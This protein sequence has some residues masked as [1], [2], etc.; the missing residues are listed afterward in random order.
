MYFSVTKKQVDIFKP[1][2]VGFVKNVRIH[3]ARLIVKFTFLSND[4]IVSL[5]I[6]K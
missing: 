2:S 3:E 5:T 1:M 4:R 6:L